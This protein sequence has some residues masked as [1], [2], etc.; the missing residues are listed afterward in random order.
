MGYCLSCGKLRD[1]VNGRCRQ[2]NEDEQM[3]KHP[4]WA[5]KKDLERERAKREARESLI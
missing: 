3:R 5:R 2:C 1:T 4:G